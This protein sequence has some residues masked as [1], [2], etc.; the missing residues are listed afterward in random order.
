MG[1]VEVCSSK[2][3]AQHCRLTRHSG[4][5]RCWPFWQEVL[6]CYV[7]NADA[8]NPKGLRKCAPATEDYMEYV[9]VEKTTFSRIY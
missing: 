9:H 8:E 5:G 6:A 3:E 1:W 7:V 2:M 4:P